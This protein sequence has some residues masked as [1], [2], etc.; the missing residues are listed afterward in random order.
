MRCWRWI[1]QTC[2]SNRIDFCKKIT[3]NWSKH[4]KWMDICL[5]CLN[6]R[7]VL[8]IWIQASNHVAHSLCVEM[9]QWHSW[10]HNVTPIITWP[11]KIS[12]IVSI[13]VWIKTIAMTVW[14]ML[15]WL[16]L[17][18]DVVIEFMFFRRAPEVQFVFFNRRMGINCPRDVVSRGRK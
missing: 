10:Q 17:L 11:M 1:C 12:V 13:V 3:R 6:F 14:L 4:S 8:L 9:R 2:C 15:E 7:F 16:R 5:L 18:L